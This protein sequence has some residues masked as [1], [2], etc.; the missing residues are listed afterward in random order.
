MDS[1]AITRNAS[2]KKINS[3]LDFMGQAQ[4]VQVLQV[5]SP[6]RNTPLP[7]PRRTLASPPCIPR[8]RHASHACSREEALW[9]VRAAARGALPASPIIHHHRGSQDFYE[10][11]LAALEKSKNERLHFKTSL[12]LA[13]L[14]AKKHEYG[15][16][17]RS[18]KELHK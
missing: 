6:P 4:D 1:P 18:L 11:T 14:W 7:T 5:R 9:C 16:L 2:E 13:S 12:K 15:R 3:L 8:R 17:A 10:T